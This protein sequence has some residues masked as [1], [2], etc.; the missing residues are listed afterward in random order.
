MHKRLRVTSS[1]Q[2][3]RPFS[4]VVTMWSMTIVVRLARDAAPVPDGVQLLS[5]DRD[6]HQVY[7]SLAN[8]CD[9]TVNVIFLL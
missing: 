7:P 4:L 9:A 2:S 1:A 8:D 3:T 5:V 6:S